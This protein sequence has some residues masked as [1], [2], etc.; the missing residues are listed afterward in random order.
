MQYT[1]FFGLALAAL[2]GTAFACTDGDYQCDNPVNGTSS[3]EVCQNGAWA[4]EATCGDG[5][6]CAVDASGGYTCS[7]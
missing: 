3:V 6:K 1:Y 7:D 4:L 2:T 5:E